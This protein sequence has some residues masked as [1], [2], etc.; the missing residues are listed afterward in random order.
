MG[1]Y[2]QAEALGR[3]AVDTMRRTTGLENSNTLSS[4]EDLAN[5]YIAQG[6][7]A[8][9]EPI[10][11]QVLALRRRVLGPKHIAVSSTLSS[12]ASMYSAVMVRI[13]CS[14]QVTHV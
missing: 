11:R 10:L 4:M 13:V 5:I 3:Q 9:A 7:Y 12:F 1:E 2:A 14:P 8:E 6:K